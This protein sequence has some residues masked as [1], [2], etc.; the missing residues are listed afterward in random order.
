MGIHVTLQGTLKADGTLELDDKVPM[1]AGRVLVTVQPTS[2]PEAQDPFWQRMEAIWAARAT[3][4]HA[5]G[6]F[7]AHR[8]ALRN[9]M[10]EEIQEAMRLRQRKSP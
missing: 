10:E 2:Q 1:P 6:A 8:Q 9:E 4:A 3:S 5:P 7:E